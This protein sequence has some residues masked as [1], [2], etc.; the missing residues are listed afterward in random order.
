VRLERRRVWR[1]HSLLLLDRRRTSA[2]SS[3]TCCER[4]IDVE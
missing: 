4:H 3:E 1:V 2:A